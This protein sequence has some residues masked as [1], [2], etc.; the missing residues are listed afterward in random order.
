MLGSLA[1]KARQLIDQI[2]ELDLASQFFRRSSVVIPDDLTILDSGAVFD[3]ERDALEYLWVHQVVREAGWD[4]ELY[5]VIPLRVLRYLPQEARREVGLSNRMQTALIGLYNQRVA[6]YDLVEMKVGIYQGQ[7]LGAIQLYGVVGMAETQEEAHHNASL[8]MAAL[9]GVMSNFPQARLAPPTIWM[10]RWIRQSFLDFGYALVGIGHPQE[11]EGAR[12]MGREGP[13]EMPTALAGGQTEQQ[14][15]MFCRAMAEAQEEY[16]A[17]TMASRVMLRDLVAML[18]DTAK[19]ASR[20]ASLMSGSESAHAIIALPLSLSSTSTQAAGS[21]I[22]QS[23]SQGASDGIAASESASF[24]ESESE[25][26]GHAV[27]DGTSDSSGVAHSSGGSS[28]HSV[29]ISDSTGSSEGTSTTTGRATSRGTANTQ[30]SFS[31]SSSATGSSWGVSTGTSGSISSGS[32]QGV[33]TGS[34][35]GVSSGGSQSATAGSSHAEGQAVGA[36]LNIGVDARVGGS[37]GVGSDVTLGEGIVPA[38]ISASGNVG[39]SGSVGASVGTTASRTTS[40]TTG[41]SEAATQGASWGESDVQSQTESAVNTVATSSG[42]AVTQSQGGFSSSGAS[43]GSS[44]STTTSQG[45]TESEAESHSQGTSAGRT[46]STSTGSSSFSSTTHSSSHT[47]SHSETSSWAQTTG[48]AR[49]TSTG[50]TRSHGTSQSVGQ[51]VGR[52]LGISRGL[53]FAAGAVPSFGISRS[54]QWWN[55][56][57]IQL[58]HIL[59][60]QE[61]LLRR[62]T[63]EGAWRVDHTILTRT[64]RGA[65]T[66]ETAYHQAYGGMSDLTVTPVQTRRLAQAE[67]E[68]I[69]LHAMAFTPATVEE[70][71]SEAIETYYYSTILNQG[72][73][74][75]YITPA[76]FEEGISVTTQERIPAF[77]YVPDMPGDVVLAHQFST[78][79]GALTEAQLRL[80]RDRHTHTLFAAD[81]RFGKSVAAERV[82]LETTKAWKT[83]TVVFDF[84]M[85]WRKMLNASIPKD[86]VEILQLYPNAPVPLRFNPWQVP[87]RIPANTLLTANCELFKNAG[88]MGPKQLGEMRRTAQAMYRDT[89]VLTAGDAVLRSPTWGAV[90]DVVE[91]DAINAYRQT[92][93]LMP[94]R[95]IGKS[96]GDLTDIERHALAIHRSQAVGMGDWLG[97]LTRQKKRLEAKGQHYNAQSVEG[98]LL[99]L[100]VFAQGEMARMYGKGGSAVTVEDLGLLGPYGD[101]WGI[102]VI[103]GGAEMDEFAAAALMALMAWRLYTDSIVRRRESIGLGKN[104]LVQIVLEEANKILCGISDGEEGRPG[105]TTSEYLLRMFRDGA[106]YG[107]VYY[108]IL[109][110]MAELHAAFISSCANAWLSQ[111]KNPRDRDLGMAHLAYSEKGFVDEDHKRFLSRVAQGM[112]LVKLGLSMNI[113]HTTPFLVRPAMIRVPEPSDMEIFRHHHHMERKRE[114]WGQSLAEYEVQPWQVRSW[115]AN[116]LTERGEVRGGVVV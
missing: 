62:A 42:W 53:G 3:E 60:T 86:R 30:G 55:D 105:V 61:E 88:R 5:R 49:G 25:T 103:E 48:T 35:H 8:G 51:T 29:T 13:G 54:A 113:V 104:Q 47:V 91:E 14:G 40:E 71:V 68:Y 37:V 89:G 23:Q 50:T 52:S 90:R 74:A 18:D 83:R 101:Q 36:S 39:V 93:G 115:Q 31:S 28:S 109:Q 111:M 26:V 92:Y 57:A 20:V 38:G 17:M 22:G 11:R 108:L 107:H 87:R 12:G 27:S 7:Y 76:A 46:V 80:S 32:S 6:E 79:R 99:R 81:T 114:E 110:S 4:R 16:V 112:M 41:H 78:E 43:S 9:E 21:M 59:R 10:T 96:L 65:A 33:T 19:E 56:Q 94:E 24:F 85:G 44:S 77:A 106:K 15:E 97:R 82:A 75:A 2:E 70:T 98:I 45:I 72:Q 58:T 67:Q 69:Q 116:I 66:A 64:E 84:G 100:E 63:L 1:I 95:W 34:A 73:L 102:S